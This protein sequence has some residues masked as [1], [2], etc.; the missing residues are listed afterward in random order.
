M[1]KI[2]FF[3]IGWMKF[4]RGQTRKDKI[5][6]GG[7]HIAK[8]GT[9]GEI[10]NFKE[11]DGYYY[12]YV[13]PP[14]GKI[15]LKRIDHRCDNEKLDDVLVV[16]T[17]NSVNKLGTVIVG[18]YKNATVYRTFHSY[19]KGEENFD[20]LARAKVKNCK[21]LLI[22]QR[23]FSIPR[24]KNGIGQANVWYAD[25]PSQKKIRKSVLDYIENGI[26]KNNYR[27]KINKGIARQ[28]DPFKKQLVEK[29]AVKKTIKYYE[30]QGYIVDSVEK[31]NVGW[32]LE[33]IYNDLVLLIEVKGLS[34]DVITVDLTP[35]EYKKMKEKRNIYRLSI[36]TEALLSEPKVH[37]FSHSP[38]TN[39]WEN[40]EGRALKIERKTSAHIYL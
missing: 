13:Q 1:E 7:L 4:Y 8:T 36:V 39:K 30:A 28:P 26:I 22:D 14:K 5:T 12:G 33:A 20:Y 17:A 2:V 24:G 32:D 10:N 31:D 6:G 23:L 38:E 34:R 21:L 9:G 35:N 16:W 18:W 15:N 25:R 40:E 11:R 27:D 29:A 37:I 3:N 19:S